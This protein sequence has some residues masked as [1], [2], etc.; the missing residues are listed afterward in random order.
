MLFPAHLGNKPT[1]QPTNFP[2]N[3]PTNPPTANQTTDRPEGS[4]GSYPFKITFTVK[5]LSTKEVGK[6]DS[7]TGSADRQVINL[8]KNAR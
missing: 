1:N 6:M 4:S 8:S 2:M 3:Q 5:V 7:S